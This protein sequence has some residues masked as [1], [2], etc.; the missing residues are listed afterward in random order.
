LNSWTEGAVFGAL[1]LAGAVG[2]W[3]GKRALMAWLSRR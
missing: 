1:F 2:L 3:Y